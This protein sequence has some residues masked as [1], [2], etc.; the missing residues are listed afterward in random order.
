MDLLAFER[1]LDSTI[2]RKKLEIQ[3]ALR[4]PMKQKRKLR[5]FISHQ[6]TTPESGKVTVQFNNISLVEPILIFRRVRVCH[7][8]SW[9]LKADFSMRY[10]V[11]SVICCM[12]GKILCNCFQSGT[13]VDDKSKLRFTNFFKNLVVEL[14]RE[15]Y[16]PD[17]HLAEWHRSNDQEEMD[18]FTVSHLQSLFRCIYLALHPFRWLVQVKE[19]WN[20]PF[21]WQSTIRLVVYSM[22]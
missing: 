17:S 14:D 13:K 4:R 10:D 16:G 1:K 21:C 7:S 20:V 19:Q 8:G 6:F 11:R 18:G 2:M 9:R 3:E 15:V 22:R 5:V 12:W